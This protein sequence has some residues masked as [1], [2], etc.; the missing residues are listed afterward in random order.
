[1]EQIIVTVN[2]VPVE[3]VIAEDIRTEIN[4]HRDKE[5]RTMAVIKRAHFATTSI[6]NHSHAR[7]SRGRVIFSRDLGGTCAGI[8]LTP[9]AR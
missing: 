2:G 6:R 4:Q 9:Y 7:S 3:E 1:M 5:V 8:L